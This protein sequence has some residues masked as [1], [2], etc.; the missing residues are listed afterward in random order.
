M[1]INAE[2][3]PSYCDN[4]SFLDSPLPTVKSSSNDTAPG[5]STAEV[6]DVESVAGSASVSSEDG[7]MEVRS[8]SS[9]K[10]QKAKLQQK[11]QKSSVS[12]DERSSTVKTKKWVGSMSI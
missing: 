1:S 11:S 12:S 4:P 6:K 5:G 9:R 3:P 8:K 2:A 10:Q 7:F